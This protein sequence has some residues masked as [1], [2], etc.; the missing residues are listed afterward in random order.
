MEQPTPTSKADVDPNFDAQMENLRRLAAA[1][2]PA[3]QTGGQV[4]WMRP[5]DWSGDVFDYE[6]LH[7]PF[8]RDTANEQFVAAVADAQ[9][10]GTVG[11]LVST[12]LMIDCL[13]TM[14]RAFKNRH[15][16]GRCR[17]LAHAAG[18]LAGQGSDQGV[19]VQSYLEY[20]RRL[21]RRAKG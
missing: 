12:T 2:A 3:L 16:M 17:R 18:R 10:P 4:Q 7:T 11:D 9:A 6:D 14:E 5:Q 1:A 19:F 8:Q 15:T 21:V 20:M 13:A